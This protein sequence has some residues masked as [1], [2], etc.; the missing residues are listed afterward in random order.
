[1]QERFYV[2]TI[3]YNKEKQ[4]E[5]RTVPMAFDTLAEATKQFHSQMAKDMGNA[6]LGW[7]VTVIMDSNGS[8]RRSEKWEAEEVQEEPIE[9]IVKDATIEQ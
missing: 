4:A 5:N 9:E 7:S 8:L 3:Q 6:T 2:V 1:M